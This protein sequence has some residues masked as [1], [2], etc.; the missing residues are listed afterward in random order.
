MSDT[1]KILIETVIVYVLMFLVNFWFSKPQKKKD[2]QLE[3]YYLSGIYGIDIGKIDKRKFRIVSSLL[4]SLIITVIY[5]ILVYLVK[6]IILKILIGI[7]LLTLL[8]IIVYGI[9][10]KYY[11]WKEDKNVQS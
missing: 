6:S 10:G 5:L 9:L 3:L 4:N 11:L 2:I 1:I 7:V 8:I